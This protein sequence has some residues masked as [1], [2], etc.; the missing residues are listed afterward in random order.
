MLGVD[1][2]TRLGLKEFYIFNF[3]FGSIFTDV[4]TPQDG[5]FLLSQGMQIELGCLGVIAFL[6]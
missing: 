1:C 4:L 3:G 6:G 2:F 5:H